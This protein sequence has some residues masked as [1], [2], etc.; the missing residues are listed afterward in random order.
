LTN[1]LTLV[2]RVEQRRLARPASAACARRALERHVLE[3]VGDA[4]FC[5]LFWLF[6]CLFVV[7]CCWLEV[8]AVG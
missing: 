1:S 4:F 6:V 8:V 3:Q 7:W 5:F 2:G